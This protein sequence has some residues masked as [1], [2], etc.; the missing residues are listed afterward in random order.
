MGDLARRFVEASFSGESI[1]LT[2]F[3]A[4]DLLAISEELADSP[5]GAVLFRALSEAGTASSATAAIGLV[6]STHDPGVMTEVVRYLA[7]SSQQEENFLRGLHATFLEKSG[8]RG[9]Y[10]GVRSQ[11]LLG[12]LH[13]S[14]GRPSLA[15][16]LQAHLLD[17]DS[18][19]DGD[20]LRHVA[21]IDGLILAHVQDEELRV[22]LERLA[23]VPDAEDEASFAL[24]L[25]AVAEALDEHDRS[26]ALTSFRRARECML[27]SVTA[28]ECRR[29]AALYLLCLDVLINFQEGAHDCRLADMLAEVRKAAF[30]YA[31][32]LLPSDRPVD[33]RTWL[34]VSL[35]EGLR[36]SELA[37]RLG[38][39][40]LSLTKKAWLDAAR[41]IEEELLRVFEA[42]RSILKRTADGGIE[43]LVRPRIAGSI[44]RNTYQLAVLDQ[45]LEENKNSVAAPIAAAMRS[46]IASAVEAR[47]SRNPTVAAA[48]PATAAEVLARAALPAELAASA[49]S[50][51]EAAVSALHLETTDRFVTEV[52]ETVH[53]QLRS[54]P[55]Y[56]G[57][58]QEFFIQILYYTIAFVASRENQTPSAVPG[59]EYL[60]NRSSDAPPVEADLHKDYF[61]F[62]QATP[63]RELS[64]REVNGVAHG[65]VD[66]YFSRDGVKT[67]AELKKTNG[68]L[69]LG[70]MVAKFGL[71]AT[72]YQRTNVTLCILMVLDLVDRGG[73]SDHLRNVVGV[74][75]KIP[76]SGKT[77]YS[78]VCCR[79][80]GRKKSPS[81]L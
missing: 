8:D 26:S 18:A 50:T 32:Q 5:Q 36:W 64:Q 66:V 44:Q 74:H 59:I 81:T 75:H 22:A 38:M 34:G 60:F 1:D 7:A 79:V 69:S 35:L 49:A 24:G 6:S 19:D 29:D 62:L 16:R 63:L 73:G 77:E 67:V 71:Q 55:D 42:S 47:L 12:A 39:L 68:D 30:E 25:L 45:W 13:L 37:S 56:R 72:A 78:V 27:R 61:G 2:E 4:A 15:R 52:F 31:A 65:R 70:E 17:V 28:S 21:R 14:Q 76:P 10:N 80:Q 46:E 54:N 53:D 41:V 51:L 43:A 23:A 33:R 3:L 57:S 11:S 20:Y 9:L 40:D 58:A 48:V